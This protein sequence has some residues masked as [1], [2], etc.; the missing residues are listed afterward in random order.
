MKLNR[1][2]LIPAKDNVSIMQVNT[3]YRKKIVAGLL[4]QYSELV[5]SD[6]LGKYF[7][8][9][10]EDNGKTWLEDSPFVQFSNFKV[11][12]DRKT[13]EFVLTTARIQERSEKDIT[14]PAYQYRLDIL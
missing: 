1:T 7:Q 9:T 3:A 12:E 11:Y 10:S 4:Q 5:G 2:I 6:T 8:R 13:D 14:S